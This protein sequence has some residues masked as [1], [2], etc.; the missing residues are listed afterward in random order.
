MRSSAASAAGRA[1]GREIAS[2]AEKLL[3]EQGLAFQIGARVT[4]VERQDDKAVVRYEVQGDE[5]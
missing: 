4:G 1:P 2:S 3:A 5:R